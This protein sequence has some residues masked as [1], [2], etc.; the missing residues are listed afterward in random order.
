MSIESVFGNFFKAETQA[1]GAKLVAQEKVSI[2][3]GTDTTIQAY[4][5]IAPPLRVLL[6]T[7]DITDESFDAQCS[8]PSFKKGQLCKH[9]WATLLCVAEEYPDFLSAKTTIE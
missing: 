5:R 7:T 6:T 9:I 8:C 1:S 4:I 3:S 2:S